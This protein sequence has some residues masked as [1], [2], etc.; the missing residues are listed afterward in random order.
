MR[1]NQ[2]KHKDLTFLNDSE[3]SLHILQLSLDES[4]DF[5]DARNANNNK[6]DGRK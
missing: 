1:I 4:L 3:K 5:A 2:N 6:K